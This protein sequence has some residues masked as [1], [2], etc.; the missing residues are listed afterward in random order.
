MKNFVEPGL[1]I[2][3]TAPYAVTPGAGVLVGAIFGVACGIYANGATDCEIDLSGV[4]D[5]T[6]TSAD[7]ATVG[8]LLY[9]DNTNRRI[10][11]SSAGNTKVGVATAAKASGATTAR[12]RLN[13]AF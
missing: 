2:T 12:V 11:T 1:T 10:T 7:T 3:V 8:A 6:A 4:F 9:W 5:L 13:G